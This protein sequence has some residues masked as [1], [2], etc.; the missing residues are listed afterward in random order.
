MPE[1]IE[2]KLRLNPI[3]I[4]R[5]KRSHLVRQHLVGK[6][7]TRKLVSIYYDTPTLQLMRA[8]ISLRIRH[9]SGK[10]YQSVKTTGTAVAG[11]HSRLE[12]EDILKQGKPDFMKIS[13]IDVPEIAS[14]FANQAMQNLLAPIFNTEVKRTEWQLKLRHSS[15]ELALDVGH[16]VINGKKLADICELEIELK[17][18][19]MEDI[20]TL[21]TQ[22][23]QRFALDGENTSKAQLG[24]V[25]YQDLNKN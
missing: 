12:W 8:A 6:P 7:R 20:H 5:L 16:V 2:L 19:S 21:A 14:L 17:S 23:Q 15:L 3:D 11:L 22:L 9:M 4:V 25:L 24:Y 1:E 13:Q 18:G 10:W